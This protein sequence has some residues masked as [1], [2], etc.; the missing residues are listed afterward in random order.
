MIS[1]RRWLI[2]G[3]LA[4]ATVFAEEK[5][6]FNQHIRPILSGNCF[7]CHG[8]DAGHRKAKLRL[9][10][11]EGALAEHD[12]VRAVVPGSLEK[13]ELWQRITSTHED[14]VMPPPESHK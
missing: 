14:E 3:L 11:A 9:D 4:S 8:A 6:S 1:P 2:A 5:V 7:A 12:G 13:S 10:L